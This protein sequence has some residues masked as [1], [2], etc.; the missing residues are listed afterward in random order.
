MFAT[1]VKSVAWAGKKASH[2]AQARKK[3]RKILVS[4]IKEGIL[5][6][7]RWRAENGKIKKDNPSGGRL[8]DRSRTFLREYHETKAHICSLRRRPYFAR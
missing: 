8:G 3:N 7:V 4:V 1:P 2:A 5:Y 6:P